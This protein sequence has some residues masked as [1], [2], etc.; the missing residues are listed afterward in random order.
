[1]F[2]SMCSNGHN[3]EACIKRALCETAQLEYHEER[4]GNAPDS[5]AKEI[6]RA[7]FRYAVLVGSS[8]EISF[9]AVWRVFV[10][11]APFDSSWF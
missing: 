5:F 4:A 6:L 3:G 1:M 7:V 8:F 10:F 11:W 2:F 9:W